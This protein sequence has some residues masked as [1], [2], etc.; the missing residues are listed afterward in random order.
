MQTRVEGD[1]LVIEFSDLASLHDCLTPKL[2]RI[3]TYGT[4]V[5][6]YSG[7]NFSVKCLEKHDPGGNLLKFVR[8][9]GGGKGIRYVIGYVVGDE[10]TKEHEYRHYRYFSDPIY[11]KKCQ[12]EFWKTQH[13]P[14]LKRLREKGYRANVLIDEAQAHLGCP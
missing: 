8:R 13:E 11:R 1:L 6:E 3:E 4:S 5:E 14:F 9:S 7:L 2:V 10:K 12:T